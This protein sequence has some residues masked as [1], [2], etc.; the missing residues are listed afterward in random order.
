M[1]GTQREIVLLMA[2]EIDP[3]D[4]PDDEDYI[5]EWAPEHRHPEWDGGP[6]CAACWMA[7]YDR[8]ATDDTGEGS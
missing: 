4:A 3:Q 8:R 7:D 1:K 6:H 5:R 2:R